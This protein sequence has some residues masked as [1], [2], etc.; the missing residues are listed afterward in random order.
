MS[1]K[2]ITILERQEA[3]KVRSK[4]QAHKRRVERI[5]K[6]WYEDSLTKGPARVLRYIEFKQYLEARDKFEEI[7]RQLDRDM[8]KGG[9]KV[10]ILV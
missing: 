3:Q 1:T 8:N 5:A 4:R 2:H 7:A 6:K 10:D 9:F